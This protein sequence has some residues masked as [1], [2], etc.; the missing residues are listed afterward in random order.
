MGDDCSRVLKPKLRWNEAPELNDAVWE[1]VSGVNWKNPSRWRRISG[2]KHQGRWCR[3]HFGGEFRDE[4]SYQSY[5]ACL[6]IDTNLGFMYVCIE[7]REVKV[8]FMCRWGEIWFLKSA[9]FF[10]LE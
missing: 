7:Y 9:M 8:G 6:P 10:K 5:Y 4:L 2:E 1:L 3:G